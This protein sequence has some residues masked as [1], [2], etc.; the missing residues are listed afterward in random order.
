MGFR[1]LPSRQ[2]AIVHAR[3]YIEVSVQVAETFSL[4]GPVRL[5]TILFF[6]KDSSHLALHWSPM[7][8]LRILLGPELEANFCMSRAL[9]HIVQCSIRLIR[10]RRRR[11]LQPIC[12]PAQRDLCY[13]LVQEDWML[14]CEGNG[15]SWGL[16][17]F[18]EHKN[19]GLA[20]KDRS[21][22]RFSRALPGDLGIW[23][24]KSGLV[25]CKCLRHDK[26]LG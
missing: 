2:L 26:Q 3:N 23:L 24:R 18:P 10:S 15:T 22:L 5:V 21:S 17:C 4:G 1:A 8:T 20:S 11:V 9:V 12:H 16:S 13:P 19:G 6:K 14:H 25:P 7:I